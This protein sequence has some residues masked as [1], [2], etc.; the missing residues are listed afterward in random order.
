MSV[1]RA[2]RITREQRG[3]R[4]VDVGKDLHYSDRTISAIETG[5]RKLPRE[6]TPT[7]VRRLD[8]IL[9]AYEAAEEVSA[10]MTPP[11]LDGPKADLHRMT[12]AGFIISELRE[13]LERVDGNQV[14]LRARQGEELDA[15]ARQQVE[16]LLLE[17]VEAETALA[18]GLLV[19]CDTYQVSPLAL[20]QRHRQEL[21]MK[22]YITHEK[23]RKSA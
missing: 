8:S 13:A 17:M 14:L 21:A 23:A 1:G 18:N 20:Y 11:I 16:D 9:L 6:I 22:G 5:A 12:T 7:V 2:M 3:L 4:Q 15:A 19:I 10:G